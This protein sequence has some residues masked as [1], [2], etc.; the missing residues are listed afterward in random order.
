MVPMT[1]PMIIE[2]CM[3]IGHADV[4]IIVLQEI[5]RIKINKETKILTISR[6]DPQSCCVSP[7]YE[8]KGNHNTS[9]EMKEK[10]IF[11]ISN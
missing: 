6:D 5:G 11:V 4:E 7:K 2:I 10:Y 9:P 1:W 3:A 8:K